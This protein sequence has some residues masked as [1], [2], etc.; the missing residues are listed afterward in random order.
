VTQGALSRRT[1]PSMATVQTLDPIYVDVNQS[2]S[3]WLQ[4]RQ[5][6]TPGRVQARQGRCLGADRAE[7]GTSYAHAG[8]LQ[9]PT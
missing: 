8:K 6:S 5:R 7:N 3:E 2:S 9:L 4:L 1:R